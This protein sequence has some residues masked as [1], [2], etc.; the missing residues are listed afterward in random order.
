[1][2]LSALRRRAIM[3]AMSAVPTV[4]SATATPAP[5]LPAGRRAVFVEVAIVLVIAFG[6]STLAAVRYLAAAL[7]GFLPAPSQALVGFPTIP[8]LNAIYDVLLWAAISAPAALAVFLVVRSGAEPASLGIRRPRWRD[9]ALGL[10]LALGYLLLGLVMSV[11]DRFVQ[12][13]THFFPVTP[14]YNG[15]NGV[16]ASVNA[17]ILEETVVLAYVVHRLEVAGLRTRSAAAISVVVRLAY[18]VYYGPFLLPVLL[19]GIGQTLYFVRA[20]RLLPL[21]FGHAGYDLL[22]LVLLRAVIH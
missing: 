19:F 2:A 9:A 3:T 7:T 21:V 8:W 22:V 4:E 10:G 14:S 6:G 1:M 18:H 17:G 20:R 15:L 16:L 5:A 11:P 13:I 12:R